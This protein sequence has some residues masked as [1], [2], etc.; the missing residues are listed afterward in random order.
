MVGWAVGVIIITVLNF[1][2]L[3]ISIFLRLSSSGDLLSSV[4]ISLFLFRGV[5][6]IFTGC[7]FLIKF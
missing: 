3:P 2:T 1:F 7:I 4:V 6:K 5:L